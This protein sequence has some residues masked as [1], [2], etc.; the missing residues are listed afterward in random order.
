MGSGTLFTD[1]IRRATA[2]YRTLRTRG[3]PALGARRRAT[4]SH[5]S[6]HQHKLTGLR[7]LY[8]ESK[9]DTPAGAR[10]FWIF[11]D[12]RSPRA[13]T[14]A[15]TAPQRSRAPCL[16]M[17]SQP[18]SFR[19]TL[20]WLKRSRIV[21]EEITGG[22]RATRTELQAGLAARALRIDSGGL[23]RR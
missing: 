11:F 14:G 19:P 6:E 4:T 12:V 21:L 23:D 1:P 5:S 17:S 10:T 9:C 20:S 13:P 7:N 8:K 18:S 22:S 2:T 16:H 3:R 15:H